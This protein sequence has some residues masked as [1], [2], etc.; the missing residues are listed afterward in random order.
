LLPYQCDLIERFSHRYPGRGKRE[1]A[2]CGFSNKFLSLSECRKRQGTLVG[3]V[4]AQHL[5]VIGQIQFE[6][7]CRLFNPGT[8]KTCAQTWLLMRMIAN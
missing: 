7:Q 8:V 4:W 3:I 1:Q 6:G 5:L 2:L